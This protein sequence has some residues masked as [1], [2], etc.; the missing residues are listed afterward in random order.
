MD[1]TKE[2]KLYLQKLHSL[3]VSKGQK[4]YWVKCI[5]QKLYSLSVLSN[6]EENNDLQN[7]LVE[8]YAM[9]FGLYR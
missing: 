6:E 7:I 3:I 9:D 1:E 5:G 8:N 4:L 2:Q